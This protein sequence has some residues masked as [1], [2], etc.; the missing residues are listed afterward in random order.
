MRGEWNWLLIIGFVF[1]VTDIP[2]SSAIVIIII[3]I[4]I[5]I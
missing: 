3:I 5:I 2:E 4:I 1:N